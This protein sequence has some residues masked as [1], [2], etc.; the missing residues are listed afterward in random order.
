MS[1]AIDVSKI[2]DVLLAD[3]WHAVADNSFVTD[4]YEYVKGAVVLHAGG[5][6]GVCSTGFHFAEA[7]G[8]GAVANVEGPLTAILAVRTAA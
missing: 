4:A 8:R 1:L 3:G 2:S 7:A 6:S 5:S